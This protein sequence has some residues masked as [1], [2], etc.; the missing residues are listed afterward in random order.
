MWLPVYIYVALEGITL[1]L[2]FIVNKLVKNTFQI[3]YLYICY[4]NAACSNYWDFIVYKWLLRICN[5]VI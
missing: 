5:K 2:F 1:K 4:K 3:S